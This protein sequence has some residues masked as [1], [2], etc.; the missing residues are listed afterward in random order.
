MRFFHPKAPAQTSH[1]LVIDVTTPTR[2]P[3]SLGGTI[4]PLFVGN[5][6]GEMILALVVRQGMPCLYGVVTANGG[7]NGK[8]ARI[9]H[10]A[11]TDGGFRN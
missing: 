4:A 9:W 5:W 10:N 6:Y 7:G 1:S 3:F 11:S 8:T 2:L